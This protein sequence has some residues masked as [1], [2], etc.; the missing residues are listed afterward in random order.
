LEIHKRARELADAH[1]VSGPPFRK[2]FPEDH[3]LP[4]QLPGPTIKRIISTASAIPPKPELESEFKP[5][6]RAPLMPP[7]PQSTIQAHIIEA[8]DPT[9]SLA[10][11]DWAQIR[12]PV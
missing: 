7:P 9:A 3:R 1:L 12:A 5:I 4:N 11:L 8:V 2:Y 6:R 10:S